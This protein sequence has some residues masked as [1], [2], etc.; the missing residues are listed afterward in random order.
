MLLHT[1]CDQCLQNA[2]CWLTL[3]PCVML[4]SGHPAG[5]APTLNVIAASR[6]VR[7]PQTV[8]IPPSVWRRFRW[9]DASSSILNTSLSH[10]A[11]SMKNSGRFFFCKSEK[12]PFRSVWCFQ[13]RFNDLSEK[14]NN[15]SLS[16]SFSLA[17]IIN[18]WIKKKIQ[19]L[20]FGQ[21]NIHTHL[22]Q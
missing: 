1:F 8:E 9:S 13:I 16:W 12:G 14:P 6:H 4:S 3:S 18:Y 11:F 22:R 2:N 17:M 7:L 20:T 5:G 19:A 15:R 10:G 21:A